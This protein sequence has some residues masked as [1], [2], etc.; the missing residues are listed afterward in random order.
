MSP[1]RL[2]GLY[3]DV[4]AGLGVFLTICLGLLVAALI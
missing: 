3:A 1:L 4:A 2:S